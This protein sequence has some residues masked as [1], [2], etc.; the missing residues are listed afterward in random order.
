ME[1]EQSVTNRLLLALDA[2]STSIG[3]VVWNRTEDAFVHSLVWHAPRTAAIG[4]R[5]ELAA[6]WL[7]ERVF[8]WPPD[9]LAYEG[10]AHRTTPLALIAQQRMVGMVLY[11]AQRN[12]MPTIEVPPAT[13]KKA[14]TGSGNASKTLMLATART[15]IGTPVSEHESDALGVALA[16]SGMIK[17][18]E[19]AA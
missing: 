18:K 12:G 1:G 10:P 16:A 8:L 7:K 14:L 11:L 13:A 4:A 3:A 2:S 9:V 15:I 17:H 19:Y 5:I 6:T